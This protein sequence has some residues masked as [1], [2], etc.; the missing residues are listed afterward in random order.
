MPNVRKPREYH[1]IKAAKVCEALVM[2]KSLHEALSTVDWTLADHYNLLANEN[3]YHFQI[4]AALRDRSQALLERTLEIEEQLSHLDNSASSTD[5]NAARVRADILKTVALAYDRR[6]SPQNNDVASKEKGL[7]DILR[8]IA[9]EAES[10][11]RKKRANNSLAHHSE[12]HEP[13]EL[14]N[15]DKPLTH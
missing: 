1:P 10:K 12:D 14:D 8:E 2:G 6:L 3:Q 4:D 13:L 11:E 15:D 7:V 5:V 9:E